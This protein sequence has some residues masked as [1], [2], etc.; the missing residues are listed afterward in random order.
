VAFFSELFRPDLHIAFEL[1]K[2]P[3][4]ALI[5]QQKKVEL[6]GRRLELH[7][8]V[9]QGD[10]ET[11]RR[12]VKEALQNR[13]I[14]EV[15]LVLDDASHLYGPSKASFEATFPFL[16][17]GGMYVLEDWGWAHWSAYQQEGA[18]YSKEPALSNLVFQMSMLCATRRDL[19][20]QLVINAGLVFAQRG[21]GTLNDDP[22]DIDQIIKS[23]GKQLVLI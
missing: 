1:D 15:D 9:N 6:D 22:F 7:Y 18:P 20:P 19:L 4:P 14:G 8:G 12:I 5:E 2:A 21:W 13:G 10:G 3:I 16:R 23:R 11:V 17:R